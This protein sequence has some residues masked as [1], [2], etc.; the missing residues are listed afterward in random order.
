MGGRKNGGANGWADFHMHGEARGALVA[1]ISQIIPKKWFFPI[2]A[3]AQHA[4]EFVFVLHCVF[5]L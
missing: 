3:S 1:P 2:G 5:F 4:K